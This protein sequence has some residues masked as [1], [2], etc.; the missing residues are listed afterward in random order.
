ME[1]GRIIRCAQR[2][3]P[4]YGA[5]LLFCE[6]LELTPS[7]YRERV[8]EELTPHW[9][10]RALAL[11]HFNTVGQTSVIDLCVRVPRLRRFIGRQSES[12]RHSTLH[13]KSRRHDG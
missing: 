5:A 6:I 7:R 1:D 2:N 12:A 11:H 3:G 10:K 8:I 9:H 4:V 13:Q